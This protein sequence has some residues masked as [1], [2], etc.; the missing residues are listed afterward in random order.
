MVRYGF[1]ILCVHEGGRKTGQAQ[2]PPSF[3]C[4]HELIRNIPGGHCTERSPYVQAADYSD[5]VGARLIVV[6]QWNVGINHLLARSITPV[7]GHQPGAL[8]PETHWLRVISQGGIDLHDE[9]FAHRDQDIGTECA[10]GDTHRR[11]GRAA[12]TCC[13]DDPVSSYADDVRIT[14]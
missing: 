8:E 13:S 10:V 9:R 2:L 6:V 7:D 1:K 5:R 3:Q 14:A 4:S 12:E 11:H